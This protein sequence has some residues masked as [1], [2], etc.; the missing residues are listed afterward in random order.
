MKK[1]RIIDSP[2]GVSNILVP[3]LMVKN[4]HIQMGKALLSQLFMKMVEIRLGVF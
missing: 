3:L 1:N 4:S 2:F